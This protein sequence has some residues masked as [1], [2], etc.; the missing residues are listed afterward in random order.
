MTDKADMICRQKDL[1]DQLNNN[2]F[3]K[4]AFLT[5]HHILDRTLRRDL[6]ALAE[7]GEIFE[8]RLGYLRKKCLGNLT[9]KANEGKLSDNLQ[10]SIVMSGVTQKAEL[11]TEHLE[12][13]THRTVIELDPK[14]RILLESAA[15]NYIKA[16]HTRESA[17]IH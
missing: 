9:K 15:R 2:T 4:Q 10:Y 6:N 17:S 16:S 8:E 3:N 1:L 11:K 5:K 12:D 7:R 13:I 14:D